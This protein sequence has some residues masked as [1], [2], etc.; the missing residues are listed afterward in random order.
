MVPVQQQPSWRQHPLSKMTIDHL[1]D[2]S[3]STILEYFS[4]A[5]LIQL[6]LVCARFKGLIQRLCRSKRT[7]K[8]FGDIHDVYDYCSLL[9]GYNLELE[10]RFRLPTTPIHDVIIGNLKY[11]LWMRQKKPVLPL[12]SGASAPNCN[13]LAELFPNICNLI[14]LYSKADKVDL[15]YLLDQWKG[16]LTSF[17]LFDIPNCY[18]GPPVLPGKILTVLQQA[19]RLRHLDLFDSL[20]APET[21][22]KQAHNYSSTA[23]PI[24]ELPHSLLVRLE[25]FSL[26]RYSF[27]VLPVLGKLGPKLRRL[28]LHKTYLNLDEFSNWIITN[29]VICSRLTHLIIGQLNYSLREKASGIDMGTLKCISTFCPS[30]QALS[31]VANSLVSVPTC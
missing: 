28:M 22:L 23:K 24:F 19:Q 27:D 18:F 1:D 8:L 11:S 17:S 10:Q 15:P 7:L 20:E 29:P 14:V 25:S 2:N 4:M 31:I 30:L 16:T 6:R 13:F 12:P 3:L 5:E 21:D 9:S 26:C